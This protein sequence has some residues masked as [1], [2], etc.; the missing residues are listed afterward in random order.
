MP[1]AVNN[2]NNAQTFYVRGLTRFDQGNF[3]G[4][5]ADFTQAIQSQDNYSEAF[6][7][8]GLAY[9]EQNAFTESMTDYN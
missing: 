1:V 5:I 3:S 4:A 8:R 9:F 7:Y 6:F 2:P